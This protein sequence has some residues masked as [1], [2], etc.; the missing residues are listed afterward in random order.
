MVGRWGRRGGTKG[1]TETKMKAA[2][3]SRGPGMV[4]NH[5]RVFGVALANQ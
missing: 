2:C 3:F 1:E 4:K 5:Q